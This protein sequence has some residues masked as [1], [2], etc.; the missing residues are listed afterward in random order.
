MEKVKLSL[1]SREDSGGGMECWASI[2]TL[3]F[4]TTVMAEVSVLRPGRTSPSSEFLG[5]HSYYKLSGPQG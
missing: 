2:L 3:T 4:G 1:T 5:T